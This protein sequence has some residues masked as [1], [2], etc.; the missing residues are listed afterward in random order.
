MKT[1]IK[2]FIS[3]TIEFPGNAQLPVLCYKE[4]FKLDGKNGANTIMKKFQLHQ[5]YKIWV[6]GI[7]DFHH[8]HSNNHEVLGIATGTC[9]VQLGGD[10]GIII[11]VARGD[12]LLIPAGVAHKNLESSKNFSCVGA[13]SI[14]VD[15]DIKKKKPTYKKLLLC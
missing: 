1:H 4:A 14:N 11:E 6:N 10:A 8:Y 15:Y 3:E 7:Y 2:E 12:V 9:K 5:W 13:Y